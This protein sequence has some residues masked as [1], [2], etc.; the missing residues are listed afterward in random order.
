MN[1]NLVDPDLFEI[2]ISENEQGPPGSYAMKV[3]DVASSPNV[4]LD[5][6]DGPWQV[7]TLTSDVT[8]LEV[9]NWP[10][11]A[12]AGRLVLEIINTGSFGIA[13]WPANTRW[14]DGAPP[15]VSQ[16]AGKED[17]IVLST[18]TGGAKIFG[19]IV[20]QDFIS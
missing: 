9:V 12:L 16:G 1:M 20:G 7:L 5:Y 10:P 15:V 19:S 3:K 8:T 2:V 13:G 6:L 17:V 14:V 11:A 18:G 4:I